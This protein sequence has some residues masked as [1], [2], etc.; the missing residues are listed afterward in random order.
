MTDRYGII[1]PSLE[2]FND[3]INAINKINDILKNYKMTDEIRE[4]LRLNTNLAVYDFDNC[5]P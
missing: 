1:K 4:E 5:T 2:R 3:N